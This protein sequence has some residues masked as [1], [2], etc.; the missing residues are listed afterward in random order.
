M[1]VTCVLELL[2]PF[3]PKLCHESI[4]IAWSYKRWEN[5]DSLSAYMASDMGNDDVPAH[6]ASCSTSDSNSCGL[7]C[8]ACS[9]RMARFESPWNRVYKIPAVERS[10]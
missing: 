4:H 3:T 1:I 8:L 9:A 5:S 10:N 7:R 2:A 6:A